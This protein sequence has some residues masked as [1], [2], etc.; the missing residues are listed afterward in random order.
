[1]GCCFCLDISGS[2]LSFNPS[3]FR[4]DKANNTEK[5]NGCA[6]MALY[7]NRLTYDGCPCCQFCCLCAVCRGSIFFNNI[8][9]LEDSN[10]D[11]IIVTKDG[12]KIMFGPLTNE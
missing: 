11:I 3:H 12:A 7:G 1:M 4:K 8:H 10:N 5:Y 9:T 6:S 2:I